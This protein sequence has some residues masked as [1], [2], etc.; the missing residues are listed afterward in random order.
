[1]TVPAKW[2]ERRDAISKALPEV[3]SGTGDS[4]SYQRARVAFRLARHTSVE[5]DHL[6]GLREISVGVR[7]VGTAN[8]GDY[9][10]GQIRLKR[11]LGLNHA[12]DMGITATLTHEIG[13]H[14]DHV[15]NPDQFM[16]STGGR[17]EAVAENYADRHLNKPREEYDRLVHNR[18]FRTVQYMGGAAGRQDYMSYRGTGKMPGETITEDEMFGTAPDYTP[19]ATKFMNRMKGK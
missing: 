8:A 6:V 12:T 16:G 14:L 13:H 19:A 5:P 17:R 15:L 10:D 11:G 3:T 7:D 18:D 2:R 1:M 4:A 9:G